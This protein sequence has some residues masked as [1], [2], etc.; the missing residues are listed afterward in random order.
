MIY[1]LSDR[2]AWDVA[3]ARG[4]YSA[5]SLESEGFIHCS[6]SDQVEGVAN[7]FF[8]G[9]ADL[10]LLCIDENK[11]HAELRRE[12]PAHPKPLDVSRVNT[13]RLFPHLYGVLNLD[14]VV[15]VYELSERD[16][17]FALPPGLP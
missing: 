3:Q 7:D 13:D 12:A 6:T 1:H 16:A 14:A 5:P 8:R 15:A 11:L 10:L 9:E 17:G 2:A 4:K